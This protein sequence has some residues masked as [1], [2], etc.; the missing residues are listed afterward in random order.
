[1]KLL[2]LHFHSDYSDGEVSLKDAIRLV[3][4][5]GYIPG[6]ADHVSPYHKIYDD[7][8]FN[9]YVNALRKYKCWRA[10]ELCV[11][12]EMTLRKE[13]MAEIDYVIAGVHA[14][15]NDDGQRMFLWSKKPF[16][17]D[18]NDAVEL[19]LSMLSNWLP[20][21]KV[22]ILAHPTFFP[23]HFFASICA[24]WTETRQIRLLDLCE[25]HGLAL[26]MSGHWHVPD[27]R[28]IEMARERKIMLSTGSDGHT[29]NSI[30]DLDYPKS[31]IEKLS[32]K[33]NEL[34]YPVRQL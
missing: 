22:D 15:K 16:V 2:D 12:E 20:K 21:Q 8:V 27:E 23:R 11:G 26:E 32:I 19:Y 5:R 17:I 29:I 9:V 10:M 18:P 3:R 4:S 34:Y 28:L 7:V 1:M 31:M 33:E 30:G 24:P 6:V 13:D 14:L 25:K